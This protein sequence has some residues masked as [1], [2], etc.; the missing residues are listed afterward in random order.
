MP[1]S[2]S[3]NVSSGLPLWQIERPDFTSAVP[4][5][6]GLEIPPAPAEVTLDIAEFSSPPAQV[7]Q[8]ETPQAPKQ[9]QGKKDAAQEKPTKTP[10]DSLAQAVEQCNKE[11]T[12]PGKI[13]MTSTGALMMEDEH[14]LNSLSS[15]QGPPSPSS[16][17][18]SPGPKAPHADT[19]A[20]HAGKTASP[21]SKISQETGPKKP[22]DPQRKQAE[23]QR[24]KDK[25]DGIKDEMNQ[26]AGSLD[27]AQQDLGETDREIAGVEDEKRGTDDSDHKEEL[28]ARL[29]ELNAQ[30]ETKQQEVERL[31]EQYRRLEAELQQTRDQ[32]WRLQIYDQLTDDAGGEQQRGSFLQG[33]QSRDLML[34]QQ[35]LEQKLGTAARS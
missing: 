3:G 24:L 20:A 12:L 6:T 28:D 32:L 2:G 15:E 22:L 10:V 35:E 29:R 5:G 17:P 11:G 8:K 33:I 31:Q 26:C 21:A 27:R 25:I 16:I 34:R 18:P 9:E 1:V 19:H 7:L 13:S 14:C 4:L 23:E 30:R